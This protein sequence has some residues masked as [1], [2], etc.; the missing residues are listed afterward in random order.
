[1]GPKKYIAEE[2]KVD[3]F[4]ALLWYYFSSLVIISFY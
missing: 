2:N 3:N 1:M 4:T